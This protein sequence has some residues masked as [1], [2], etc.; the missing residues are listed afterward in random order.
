MFSSDL[1]SSESA[2]HSTFNPSSSSTW[3]EYEGGSWKISYGDG[4]S[5]SGTVGFDEVNIGGA[6]ATKQAVEIA[7]A[8]SGSFVKDTNNDGLVGLGFSRINTV[9]PEQQKTF[10]E[11]IMNDLVQPVFTANLEDNAAGSYT[12]GEIDTSQYSGDIHFTSIDSSNGFWQFDSNTYSIGG[13][14]NPCETCSPAIADT[15]TSLILL[16]DDIVQAYYS[17]I[18]SAQNSYAQGGYIYDCSDTLPS[19][20]VAIG[21]SGF[22]ATIQ[23]S[24]MTFAEIGDGTCFGGL[25]SNQGGGLQI[26]GDMLLKHFFAVFD[27][28]NE[29]F[30]LAAKA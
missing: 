25:Q 4:S 28:G 6:T 9:Q 22:T 7:T 11:N 13:T 14:S 12:F 10:F 1:P 5:A 15:G 17:Q 26:M 30:G 2:G 23:G 16:D 18:S 29:S 3:S 27:G 24:D 19:L 21:N 8:V 20:G